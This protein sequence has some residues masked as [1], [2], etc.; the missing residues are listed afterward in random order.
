MPAKSEKIP[1]P[2]PKVD[3]FAVLVQIPMKFI[4]GT[5]GIKMPNPDPDLKKLGDVMAKAKKPAEFYLTL[6]GDKFSLE[7]RVGAY[8]DVISQVY[9]AAEKDN[10]KRR[11]ILENLVAHTSLYSKTELEQFNKT[12]LTKDQVD[13]S[14]AMVSEYQSKVDNLKKIVQALANPTYEHLDP[15]IAKDFHDW[16]KAHSTLH[17]VT[18]LEDLDANIDPKAVF[19]KYIKDGADYPVNLGP[20]ISG[21]IEKALKANQKPD[22]SLA[23]K[24]VLTVVNSALLSKFKREKLPG[25]VKELQHD[26]QYLDSVKKELKNAGE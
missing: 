1:P 23:R 3:R 2:V 4:G 12:H 7:L 19:E 21:E 6:D 15:V 17:Y 18:F 13:F 8:K 10:D 26:S 22:F 20:Q 11:V 9:L 14:R 5:L 16:T 25:Y 24:R